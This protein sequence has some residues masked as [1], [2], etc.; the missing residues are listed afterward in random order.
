MKA[1]NPM[2]T[3]QARAKMSATLR[4]IGHRPPWSGG[5]GRGLTVPQNLLMAELT[6]LQTGWFAEFSLTTK[7][8]LNLPKNIYIDLAHPESK[9][10]VEV[11][12]ASHALLKQQDADRRK[13]AFLNGLGWIVLRFSNQEVM[14]RSAA[15]ALTATST[16]SR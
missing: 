14:A 1:N 6:R 10:A 12:G 8:A 5:N 3:A 15:C 11:D 16:T 7:R 13:T 9:T 2:H 4:R